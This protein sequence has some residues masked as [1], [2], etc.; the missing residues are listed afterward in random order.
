MKMGASIFETLARVDLRVWVLVCAYITVAF[1]GRRNVLT[2]SRLD[3]LFPVACLFLVVASWVVSCV[4]FSYVYPS[5]PLTPVAHTRLVGCGAGLE[6]PLLNF[7]IVQLSDPD[8][9]NC[10]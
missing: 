10:F 5:S 2:A 1:R 7:H 3:F 8:Y 9:A 4:I 6:V